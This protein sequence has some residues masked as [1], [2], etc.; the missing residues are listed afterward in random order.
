MYF[1]PHVSAQSLSHVL[2]VSPP[3]LRNLN[4]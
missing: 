1:Y 3:L 4:V 2:A